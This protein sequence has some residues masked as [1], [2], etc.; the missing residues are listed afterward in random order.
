MKINYNNITF[1]CYNNIFFMI[2]KINGSEIILN[3]QYIKDFSFEN[4]NAPE[5]YTYKDIK[6]KIDVSI[7]LNATKIQEDVFELSMA[8]NINAKSSEK[9]MFLVELIYSGLF[10][11]KNTSDQSL[12]EN[13]FIDCPTILFPFARTIIANATINANFPPVMLD[14]IDFEQLYASKKDSIINKK[15]NDK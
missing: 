2:S 6:P 10:T 3:T 15:Q 7:D 11:I 14:I 12:Q 1:N 5:V 4:P 9:T 13:L 8:I